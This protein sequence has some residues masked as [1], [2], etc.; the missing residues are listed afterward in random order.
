MKKI[1]L[2]A[3]R[4]RRP[5]VNIGNTSGVSDRK[6]KLMAQQLAGMARFGQPLIVGSK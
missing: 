2:K 6:R 4:S 5:A 3:L 1:L